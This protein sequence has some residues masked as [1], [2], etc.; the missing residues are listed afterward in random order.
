MSDENVFASLRSDVRLVVTEAPAGTGKTWQGAEFVSEA[1]RVQTGTRI[2]VLA[3]THAA[4]DVFA[5][6]AARSRFI[7][8]RTIDSLIAE[9]AGAYYSGLNLPA[10]PAAWARR[11]GS[12]GYEL[13]AAKAAQLVKG[14]PMIS[15]ALAQRYGIVVCD[16]HQDCT[17]DQHAIVMAMHEAGSKLRIFADPMQSIFANGAE[18]ARRH[19]RWQEL[20]ARAD[21][22]ETLDTPH[23]WERAGTGNLGQWIL[24]ARSALASGGQIDLRG[25]LP[26][27]VTVI[28]ADNQARRFGYYQLNR[29]A[30]RPIDDII[31]NRSSLLILAAQNPTTRGLR[32]FFN[33]SIPLW[34]GH[35]RD[36]LTALVAAVSD[37]AGDL[38]S[39]AQAL[40]AFLADVS[41]GLSATSFGAAF[42]NEVTTGCVARRRLKPAKIQNLA[43]LLIEQ[44]NHKGV[45]AVITALHGL[46]K[47]DSDFTDVKIDAYRE[48]CEAMRLQEFDHGE[49]GLAE[50]TRRLTFS[51]PSP[52][53]RAICTVHKAKGLECDHVVVLPCDARHFD[54]SLKS[55]CLLYVALSRGKKSLTLVIPRSNPSPLFLV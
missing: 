26:P 41:V 23:R 30:R 45:A 33:R 12:D 18:H 34:E 38:P 47:E 51:R 21:R 37:S 36:A 27:G 32:S 15:H 10:D 49:E 6:R 35:T 14:A 13:L 40:T 1:A 11:Q 3:H 42:H 48:F 44:P 16:E 9:V 29:D 39:V 22:S 54:D 31:S 52:P 25:S 43:R 55:R 17:D 19:A 28:S 20:C 7:D 4:C 50:I 5:G 2:L 53:S 8:I 46:I 24:Q